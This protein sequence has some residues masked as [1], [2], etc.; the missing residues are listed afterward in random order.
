MI[1][2]SKILNEIKL[3]NIKNI[4]IPLSVVKERLIN[5][6]CEI[7]GDEN[8]REEYTR[9]ISEAKYAKDL[10]IVLDGYGYRNQESFNI[11]MELLVE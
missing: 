7:D 1:K 8:N 6:L 10:I 2:L 9:D 3:T 5:Y 11:L 4:K